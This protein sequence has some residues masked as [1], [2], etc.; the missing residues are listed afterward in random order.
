[1]DN[2]IAIGIILTIVIGFFY[3]EEGKNVKPNS[4]IKIKEKKGLEQGK[5]ETR[6][7][8]SDLSLDEADLNF[9]LESESLDFYEG[10]TPNEADLK[11]VNLPGDPQFSIQSAEESEFGGEDED[12]GFGTKRYWFYYEDVLKKYG[13]THLYHF[14]D[15][16]NLESIYKHGG[17]YSWSKLKLNNINVAAMGSSEVSRMLDLKKGIQDYARLSFVKYHPMMYIAMKEGRIKKPI[18]IEVN[19]G[20][21]F[22]RETL[23][24]AQNAVKNGVVAGGRME[25]FDLIRFDLFNKRYFDLTP[26]ERP[27]YQAEVLVHSKIDIKHITNVYFV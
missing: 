18:I 9:I 19:R 26:E 16:E 15:I 12:T 22:L 6:H 14:T 7:T 10:K 5:Y 24:T 8:E 11:T 25:N 23:F 20:V 13:I 21:V 4:P 2:I 3:G 1:M 27:F 17:I